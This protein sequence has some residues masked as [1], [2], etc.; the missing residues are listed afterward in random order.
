MQ[1][2]LPKIHAEQNALLIICPP[3]TQTQILPFSNCQLVQRLLSGHTGDHFVAASFVVRG[4]LRAVQKGAL[5]FKETSDQCMAAAQDWLAVNK[6]KKFLISC[7]AS[8]NCC[9]MQ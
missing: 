3:L 9:K 7:H 4:L 5:L 6:K 2:R 1:A 8:R